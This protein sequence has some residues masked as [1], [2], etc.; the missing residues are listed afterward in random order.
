M[1]AITPFITRQS[2]STVVFMFSMYSV[3]TIY[4]LVQFVIGIIIIL[5]SPERHIATMLIQIV[6]TGI[7]GVILISNLIVNERTTEAEIKQQQEIAFV[8]N[9]SAR[10]RGLLVSVTDN[11]LKRRVERLYDDIYSSPVKSYFN[12][13]HIENSILKSINDLE[14]AVFSEDKEKISSLLSSIQMSVNERNRQLKTMN[15]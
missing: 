8:K 4:F 1:V 15:Q 6:I 2:K 11:E 7:Y 3:S 5:V 14:N 9:A 12:L 13:Q 10:I